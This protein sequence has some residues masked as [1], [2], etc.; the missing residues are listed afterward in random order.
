MQERERIRLTRPTPGE[1]GP[2]ASP[3]H[4]L[5]HPGSFGSICT[6]LSNDRLTKVA[7]LA[8]LF[9][10]DR[11]LADFVNAMTTLLLQQAH[12]MRKLQ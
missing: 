8:E 2:P 11:E 3:S 9:E 6:R 10:G 4:P 5:R 1:N 12:T 7:R